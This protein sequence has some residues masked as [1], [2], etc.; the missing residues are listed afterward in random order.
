MR[1]W[2]VEQQMQRLKC[3][4][5]GREG[6]ELVLEQQFQAGWESHGSK[7]HG[8]W[9]QLCSMELPSFSAKGGLTP[10]SQTC[11]ILLPALA[12]THWEPRA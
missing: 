10:G 4:L 3:G 12:Q 2:L 9:D 5:L 11:P 1:L 6:R 8:L 7:A